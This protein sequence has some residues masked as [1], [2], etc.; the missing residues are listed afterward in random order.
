M[1]HTVTIWDVKTGN[2]AITLRG[3]TGP[4]WSVAF[5][6]DGQRLLTSSRDGTVRTWAA[7][8]PER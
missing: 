3:H 5:S 8:S 7:S 2:E 1:D 4:V 6:P